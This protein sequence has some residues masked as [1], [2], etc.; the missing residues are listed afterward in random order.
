MTPG[1]A[2]TATLSATALT[3]ASRIFVALDTDSVAVAVDL[4]RALH[5]RV[6]GVKIGKEFFT[7]HGPAG[8]ESVAAVGLPIFLDLKFHDIPNTVAGAVTAAL[9]LRP[10]IM[11]VHALGG[12]AM[13]QAAVRAAA[14]AGSSRPLLIAVTLLTSLGEEDLP[15]I[16][17]NGKLPAHVTRLAA[18]ARRCGLDG[19]VCAVSDIMAV[20]GACGPA[21]KLIVPG[22]RPAWAPAD[23]HKRALSPA[24]A[25]ALGADYLVIGRP[26][27]RA[28]D[29]VAAAVRIAEEIA[30]GDPARA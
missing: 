7:A 26:I 14:A 8:Y 15:E 13:M 4:A 24:D 23:D 20:R 5:G 22:V 9:R 3:A 2:S 18:L 25:L 1:V 29:P 11:N 17:L 21:F 19:A 16:G 28:A 30:R 10:A 6:G 12:A 27:T